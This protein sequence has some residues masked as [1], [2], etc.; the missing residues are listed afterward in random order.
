MRAGIQL[1]KCLILIISPEYNSNMLLYL[2]SREGEYLHL[3]N[4][5]FRVIPVLFNVDTH[6]A[7]RM[8]ELLAEYI[9][10]QNYLTPSQWLFWQRLFFL[11]PHQPY[12]HRRQQGQ[13]ETVALQP[14]QDYTINY[15]WSYKC[16]G[17][18]L[19]QNKKS[20]KSA[21]MTFFANFRAREWHFCQ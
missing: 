15:N 10:R 19:A 20:W 18:W 9:D 5:S 12:Q 8:D 13:P 17:M 14:L 1:S 7:C 4:P 21:W 2:A 6:C 11:L 3:E 16:S